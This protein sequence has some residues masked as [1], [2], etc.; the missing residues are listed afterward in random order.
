MKKNLTILFLLA[1]I[2][3]KTQAQ[4]EETITY[5]TFCQVSDNSSK[6]PKTYYYTNIF[7]FKVDEYR[8]GD[9]ANVATGRLES[10]FSS[11]IYR[12]TGSNYLTKSASYYST[13]T[14]ALKERDR[15]MN[16]DKAGRINPVISND[17]SFYF[18]KDE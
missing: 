8:S 13:Y 14:E 12:A 16:L 17:F 6:T 5:Y 9:I 1:I 2:G 3:N 10:Q 11:Y 15:R 18:N 7:S 4:K